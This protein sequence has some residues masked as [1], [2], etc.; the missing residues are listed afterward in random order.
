MY[1][2]K[3]L[4]TEVLLRNRWYAIRR[5]DILL[6][7]GSL[8]EYNVVDR[9]DAVF[10]IPVLPDGRIVLIRHYRHTVRD[11]VWAVPAGSI[12]DGIDPTAMARTELREEIGGR[13]ESLTLV[14]DFFTMPGISNERSYVFLAR[15]VRLGTHARDPTEII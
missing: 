9:R 14:G 15:D 8:G 11:W 4:H 2:I 1:P 13:T 3:T 12:E 6:P 7:D 10:I 5:D